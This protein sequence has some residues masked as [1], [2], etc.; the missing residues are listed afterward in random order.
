MNILVVSAT[1]FEIAPFIKYM[2][3]HADKKSFF[4]FTLNGHRICPLITGV[5]ALNTAFGIARYKG[6]EE[7]GVAINAGVAGSYSSSLSPGDVVEVRSDRFADLGVEEADGSFTDVHQMGLIKDNQFPYK[8]GWIH[9]SKNKYKTGLENVTGLTVNKVHGTAESIKKITE[10]YDA[11]LETMEGAGFLY[12]C[13]M[14][15][16]NCNQIRSISNYVEPRN[17]DNWQIEKAIDNLN[18]ELISFIT[19]L[20]EE[21]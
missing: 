2:E 15:D 10:K 21:S 13:R 4:D 19:R 9:N 14:A 16:I 5:G 3:E 6:L 12:A 11:E 18:I 17:K 20:T 7:V 1:S 8:D